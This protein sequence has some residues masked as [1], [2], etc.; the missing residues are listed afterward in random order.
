M[1][2]ADPSLDVADPSLDVA[3]PSLDV[4][5]PS[6]DVTDPSLD[7]TDPSLDAGQRE[8]LSEEVEFLLDHSIF[9]QNEQYFLP[10]GPQRVLLKWD[11]TSVLVKSSSLKFPFQSLDDLLAEPK[12]L[13]EDVILLYEIFGNVFVIISEFS[14]KGRVY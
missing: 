7:V 10:K 4:A 3:V 14:E 11:C 12:L 9:F 2:V 8:S 13:S 5:V 1:D 6:L